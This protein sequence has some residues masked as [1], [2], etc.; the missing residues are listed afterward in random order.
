MD[1]KYGFMDYM[2]DFVFKKFALNP[3]I[4]EPDNIGNSNI[5]MTRGYMFGR[6]Y[7]K[8]QF[9]LYDY[10]RFVLIDLIDRADVVASKYH[11][12][13]LVD[14]IAEPVNI[15]WRSRDMRNKARK[16]SKR[17]EEIRN[18]ME[19]E[20]Q[21]KGGFSDTE[22]IYRMEGEL[23][24]GDSWSYASTAG[25]DNCLLGNWNMS[26]AL[27]SE[28]K[29]D[30]DICVEML[31]A[32]LRENSIEF[33]E[34]RF[35]MIDYL[36]CFSILSMTRN[37]H[38]QNNYTPKVLRDSTIALLS[39]VGYGVESKGGV[40]MGV[41][42]HTLFPVMVDMKTEDQAVNYLVAMK[43]NWG[44]SMRMKDLLP[45]LQIDNIFTIVVDYKGGEYNVG[46][47]AKCKY[48]NVGGEKPLYFEPMEIAEIIPDARSVASNKTLMTTA[49][50][51]TIEFFRTL[52][53]HNH[54]FNKTQF[55][56]IEE[57]VGRVYVGAGVIFEEP[58]TYKMSSN[59]DIFDVYNALLEYEIEDGEDLYKVAKSELIA[60]FKP[61]LDKSKPLSDMFKYR[62]NIQDLK[63][64]RGVIFQYGAHSDDGLNMTDTEIAL[65]QLA[66]GNICHQISLYRR[67]QGIYTA[68]IMEE[69]Q[70]YSKD[71]GSIDMLS[72]L[73]STGRSLNVILFIITNDA[74]KLLGSNVG[75]TIASN[76]TRFIL[77]AMVKEQR[78]AIIKQYSLEK[79]RGDLNDI[80][81]ND[82]GVYD[83]CAVVSLDSIGNRFAITRVSVP[84]TLEESDIFKTRGTNKVG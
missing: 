29:K 73:A 80:A 77:G 8:I 53:D 2:R 47:Y 26:L 50:K 24:R 1:V 44:K 34:V 42:I 11:C 74:S 60:A 22:A 37:G 61:Y 51:N 75:K 16:W 57:C 39:D 83:H 55:A 79:L 23:W 32:F 10:P 19:G 27:K 52:Y 5:F 68:I 59:C 63:N 66:I 56:L 14:T 31:G 67:R 4:V 25:E 72:F 49:L 3:I 9:C 30:L 84:K 45:Y 17:T 62:I 35:W 18:N 36:K 82:S 12:E 58:E 6:H 65:K 41:D 28:T 13:L 71:Q 20:K 33:R 40:C 15:N 48:I 38:S 54:G 76:M 64:E 21:R 43:T 81:L 70:E 46:K 78:E 69:V 7:K